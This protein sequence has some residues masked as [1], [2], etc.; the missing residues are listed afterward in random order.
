MRNSKSASKLSCLYKYNLCSLH[1]SFERWIVPVRQVVTRCFLI[2]C[3]AQHVMHIPNRQLAPFALHW[4]VYVRRHWQVMTGYT[5]WQPGNST[6]C[7]SSSLTGTETD[8]TP[9]TPTS[10][11]SACENYKLLSVG[12][13]CGNAGESEYGQVCQA[14]FA[15]TTPQE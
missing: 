5:H 6:I 3:G 13:Y 4:N 11:C 1:V 15:Y 9:S 10:G 14:M 7:G 12:S 8:G 2:L